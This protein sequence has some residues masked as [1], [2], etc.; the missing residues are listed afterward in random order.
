M[1]RYQ[2]QW[3]QEQIGPKTNYYGPPGVGNYQ[4]QAPNAVDPRVTQQ[5]GKRVMDGP[6]SGFNYPGTMQPAVMPRPVNAVDP[7]IAPQGGG[8]VMDGPGSGFNYPGT[9]GGFPPP[10]GG[11]PPGMDYARAAPQDNQRVLPPPMRP[12]M[13]Q[14][15]QPQ[16]QGTPYNQQGYDIPGFQVPIKDPIVAQNEWDNFQ[17]SQANAAKGQQ[18][19]KSQMELDR[20]A[21][22]AESNRIKQQRSQVQQSMPQV[23]QA[24]Q[25]AIRQ[26]MEFYGE[27]P[28][29]AYQNGGFAAR[30]A[31]AAS[32]NAPRP[33]PQNVDPGFNA[34][35]NFMPR[36]F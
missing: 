19:R 33:V 4:R 25:N 12:G 16:S 9:G 1:I 21:R 34:M 13:A 7:R 14:P 27:T 32:A 36:A 29:Q 10:S 31:Q 30:A 6:G 3:V 20:E 8:R 28:E 17:R 26:R 35:R 2:G 24:T 18:P 15:I 23:D 11:P 5:G 22:A